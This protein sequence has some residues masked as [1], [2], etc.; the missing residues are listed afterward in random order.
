MSSCLRPVHRSVVPRG[1]GKAVPRTARPTA[2]VS[3]RTVVGAEDVAVAARVDA[4][5]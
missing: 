2:R 1:V 4:V 3:P 5:V